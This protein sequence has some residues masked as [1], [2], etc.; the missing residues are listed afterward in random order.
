MGK[1]SN[2]N[3]IV[4]CPKLTKESKQC[5]LPRHQIFDIG[6][7]QVMPERLEE[8]TFRAPA[9]KKSPVEGLESS[10]YDGA[11]DIIM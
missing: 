4:Q 2:L 1:N 3:Q 5:C 10:G 8:L 9:S 11:L 7:Q 6:I